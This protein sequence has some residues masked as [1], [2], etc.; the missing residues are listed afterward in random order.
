MK[1][2]AM[3]FQFKPDLLQPE[4]FKLC[5]YACLCMQVR[6]SFLNPGGGGGKMR[7]F[8]GLEGVI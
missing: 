5:S 7:V 4:T 1:Y 8:K 2:Y 3:V 6:P